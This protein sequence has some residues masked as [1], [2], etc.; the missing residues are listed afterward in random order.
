MDLADQIRE[1]RRKKWKLSDYLSLTFNNG[2]SYLGIHFA[3]ISVHFG[4]KRDQFDDVYPYVGNRL[5]D[6]EPVEIKGWLW[7]KA[8]EP[9][10]HCLKYIGLGPFMCICKSP[11]RPFW[12]LFT[13]SR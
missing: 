12:K 4:I 11:Y 3:H 5:I 8:M 7:G 1:T 13:L 6:N 10:D 9:Y 2:F